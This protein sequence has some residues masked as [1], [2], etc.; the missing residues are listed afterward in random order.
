M[1]CRHLKSYHAQIH[2]FGDRIEAL[3][4]GKKEQMPFYE[5]KEQQ[6]SCDW[7]GGRQRA[8]GIN[9]GSQGGLAGMRALGGEPAP[10]IYV[11][12]GKA[13]VGVCMWD[14]EWE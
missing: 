3:L 5:M 1:N 8:K 10:P 2:H 9:L 13:H 12:M 11:G 14:W 6:M 4:P 7:Q